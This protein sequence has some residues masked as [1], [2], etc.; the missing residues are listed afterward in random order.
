M[1]V[2]ENDQNTRDPKAVANYKGYENIYFA[3]KLFSLNG[4]ILY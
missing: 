3:L 2:L 4:Y 1:L